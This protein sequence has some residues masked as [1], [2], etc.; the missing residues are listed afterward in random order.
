MSAS[1]PIAVAV[2]ALALASLVL[3]GLGGCGDHDDGKKVPAGE[4]R[5]VADT[6]GVRVRLPAVV[7]RV[8][9]TVPGLT[10]TLLAMGQ[11]TLLVG[12]SDQDTKEGAL[13]A[14]PHIPVYPAIPAEMVMSLR[15]DLLLV[16][17]TLSS[18]DIEVLRRRFPGT[19]ATDSRT[20]D[21]LRESFLRI[22]EA[23]DAEHRAKLLASDL[24]RA[25]AEAKVEGRPRVLLL[26]WADPP[27]ALGPG[28]LLSDMLR[29]I[30]AENV[31][32]DLGRASGEFPS[33]RVQERAPEWILLTGGTFP[34]ALRE[35]WRSVPAV[36][37]D[38]IRDLSG[39]EFVQAGPLT[40]GALRHL[41]KLLSPHD[42]GPR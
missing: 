16:D 3:L 12:V 1:A 11:G 18:H 8:V 30:G 2:R 41:A 6:A 10:S 25:R 27:M 36:A 31:A 15:P 19:F 26:T 37:T 38:R 21:G 39:N 42:E 17:Q 4:G 40:A 24:D 13:A 20:L 23:L 32:W 34:Q 9:T 14:L 22:G 5:I 7:R 28:A 29:S 33:E 35:R